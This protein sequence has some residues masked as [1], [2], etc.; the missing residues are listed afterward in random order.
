MLTP[1]QPVSSA[2][3]PSERRKRD[4]SDRA[5]TSLSPLHVHAVP[6]GAKQHVNRS[7]DSDR[8]SQVLLVR[9]NEPANRW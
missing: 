7:I 4:S 1:P 3:S 6:F 5:L 2:M 9:R 8:A